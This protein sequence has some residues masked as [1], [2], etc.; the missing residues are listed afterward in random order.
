MLNEIRFSW[1]LLGFSETYTKM[2]NYAGLKNS[3][4]TRHR[5]IFIYYLFA[6]VGFGS[7]HFARKLGNLGN[8]KE[9]CKNVI[10]TC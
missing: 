8:F 3:Y 10:V 7:K 2:Q 4:I 6:R 1:F 5:L 9:I